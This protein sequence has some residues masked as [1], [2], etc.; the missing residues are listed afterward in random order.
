MRDECRGECYQREGQVQ[1]EEERAKRSLTC[2]GTQ[3]ELHGEDAGDAGAT[4]HVQRDGAEIENVEL[5]Q[6]PTGNF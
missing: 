4:L 1:Q 3:N 2:S 5:L 6:V